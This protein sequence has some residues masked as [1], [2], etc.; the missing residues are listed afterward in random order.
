MKDHVLDKNYKK[1]N[2]G[3]K[4]KLI[5]EWLCLHG[6]H[7]MVD[8][9]FGPATDYAVRQFQK[10]EELTVDGIV[11]KRTFGKLIQPI[12]NSLTPLPKDEKSLGQ[13]VVACAE[14]HWKQSPREIGGQNKGPWVRLYMKGKEGSEWPWCAGFA[15]F[16]LKQAC[17]SLEVPLPV[18]TSVSCDVLAASAKEKGIFL[19][20]SRI[21]DK[22]QISPGSLF[23]RRRT[24]ADW[25]HTGIV[26]QP[27]NEVF[28]T[29]EG[30]TNDDGLR[31]GYEVCR[32][33]RGYKNKDFILI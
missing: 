4:V 9:I 16:I 19:G 23:L 14:Q 22:S 2:K 15:C 10:H 3:K 17:Q 26:I 24:P 28:H 21:T 27:E 12:L 13:M 1:G 25:I 11:G 29:I 5:Q 18:K 30:N 31:E 32:R 33:I 8:G 6:F 7:V 20:E